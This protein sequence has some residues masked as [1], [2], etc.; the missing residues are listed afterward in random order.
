MCLQAEGFS[1]S[2]LSIGYSAGPMLSSTIPDATK[3]RCIALQ[4]QI[5]NYAAWSLD[6]GARN[7]SYEVHQGHSWTQDNIF[8]LSR[9]SRRIVA[10]T[11]ARVDIKEKC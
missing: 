9:R 5:G 8:R 11:P 6:K 7:F 4:Y 1:F 10:A 2:Q 3:G